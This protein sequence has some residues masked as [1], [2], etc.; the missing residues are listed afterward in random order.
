MS[1]K[2]YDL[3]V[4]GAGAAGMFTA[5]H[6][7]KNMSICLI[8]K[9][10]KLGTKV[11]MSGGERCNVSNIDIEAERDYFG[12]NTKALHSLFKRFSN[13]DMIDWLESRGVR[14]HIE[15]RGR[16]ILHSGRATE[17]V[18]ILKQE[19]E[20]NNTDIFYN[21]P[22]EDIVL[23]DNGVFEVKVKNEENLHETPLS[24]LSGQERGNSN[25][26]L[27]LSPSRGKLDRGVAG[28]QLEGKTFLARKVVV[29]SGGKSFA[30]VGTDG[31]GYKIA[32][33]FGHSLND[34]FKGLCGMVTKEDLSELKGSTVFLDI[35]LYDGETLIYSEG[36]GSF[37][38]THFGVTGPMIYNAVVKLGA[39]LRAK[40]ISS[41]EEAG[42]IKDNITIK[43]RF[44]EHSLTKK[45]EKFFTLSPDNMEI[46]LHINDLRGWSEAKVT[47]GG[48]LIDELDKN[49]Q[50]KLIPNLY[51]IGEVIDITG[52]TGGFNLQSAWSEGYVV[53]K[54]L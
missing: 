16:I 3:L 33:K 43:L 17:L 1:E 47:G 19:L 50:S 35:S 24:I 37:L 46:T 21:S 8:E 32:Q 20:K 36:D 54:S 12:K 38:F 11:L 40:G 52:K 28:E 53:G 22:A 5:I 44:L 7:P 39:Y 9:S 27:A 26:E 34:P 25:L 31:W 48:V 4:I 14:T 15:D 42:Y 6:A 51:F 45:L 41:Q 18:D 23:R 30:S 13:Y 10:K 29:S 2:I 49:F